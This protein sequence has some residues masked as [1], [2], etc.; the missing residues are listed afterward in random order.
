MRFTR[1]GRALAAAKYN[2]KKSFDF[3]VGIFLNSLEG[4]AQGNLWVQPG[5]QHAEREAR[6]AGRLQPA[7]LCAGTYGHVTA[8]PI[9]AREPGTVVCFSK[10]LVHAGGPNCSPA[11]R[12]ALY[13]RLRLE[14]LE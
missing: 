3:V 13:Y 11:I 2:A 5:S 6:E 12:Y 8:Q 9:L 1:D 14:G 7:S 10:D 4:A